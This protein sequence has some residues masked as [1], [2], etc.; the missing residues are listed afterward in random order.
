MYVKDSKLAGF[1]VIGDVNRV[2]IYTSLVRNKTPLNEKM[3]DKLKIF[4]TLAIF[5]AGTRRKKLGGVV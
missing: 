2:G 1:I 3:L 5:S 4:P